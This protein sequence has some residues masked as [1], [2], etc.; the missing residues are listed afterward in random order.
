MGW[1]AA[2]TQ[3]AVGYKDERRRRLMEL[4]TIVIDLGKTVFHLVGVNVRGEVVVRKTRA[5]SPHTSRK[6]GSL[7]SD[8]PRVRNSMASK[9]LPAPAPPQISV[10][11]PRGKRPP[12]ISR[13]T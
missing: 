10:A 7:Y 13:A 4:Q 11:R 12:L 8:A 3:P 9:V 2:F 5:P 1:S 6:P